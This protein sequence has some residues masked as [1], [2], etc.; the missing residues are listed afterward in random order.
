MTKLDARAREPSAAYIRAAAKSR[1]ETAHRM[2]GSRLFRDREL[3]DRTIKALVK[4]GIDAPERLL[5]MTPEQLRVVPGV[6]NASFKEIVAYRARFL[7]D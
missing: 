7:L 6:G 5:F 4:H 3:S 1:L 2:L